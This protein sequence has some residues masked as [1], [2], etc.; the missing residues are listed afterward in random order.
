[1]YV[2]VGEGVTSLAILLL[3]RFVLRRQ[4]LAIAVFFV[5]LTVVEGLASEGVAGWFVSAAW[6]AILLVVLVRFGLLAAVFFNAFTLGLGSFPVLIEPSAW[7]GGYSLLFL[8]QMIALVVYG[9]Y[10]S[11]AG[12]PVFRD[13]L[14]AGES[15]PS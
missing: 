10:I 6:V 12:R 5:L 8:L 4:R 13:E 9:F 11:L 2:S 1:V 7:Y 14:L 15:G 3:L